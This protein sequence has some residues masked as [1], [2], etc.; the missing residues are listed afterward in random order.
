MPRSIYRVSNDLRWWGSD[1]IPRSIYPARNDFSTA[2]KHR[3]KKEMA[4]QC[5]LFF[6]YN[7]VFPAVETGVR[8]RVYTQGFNSLFLPVYFLHLQRSHLLRKSEESDESFRVVVIIEIAGCKGCE[9]LIVEAVRG[10]C[11]GLNDVAFVE[12]EFD[13]A[14]HVLLSGLDEGLLRLAK[15]R[16]PFSFIDKAGKLVADLVLD[17]VSLA[18]EDKFF[19]LL[20]RFHEDRSAG[21][22]IDAAGL[23]ADYAVLYDVDDA[24]AVLAAELVESAD[25]IG[26]FH[27]LAVNALGNALFE[28]H[29]HIGDLVGSCHGSLA[30]DQKVI[31]VGHQGRILEFETFVADV[32]EVA[33]TAVT[34]VSGEGEVDPVLFA[35]LDLRFTGVHCPLV[36]APCGDDAKIRSQSLDAEL[37]ADLVVALSGR[38]VAD[39]CSAFLAGDLYKFLG[40]QRTG[41]GGAQKVFVLIDSVGLDAGNDILLGELVID[42]Q[43]I[44]LGSAAVFCTLFE[45]IELFTLAAV[46]ADTDDVKIVVLF[47]PRDDGCGI[48]A[49]AIGEDYFFFLFGHCEFLHF[50]IYIEFFVVSSSYICVLY[51][52]IIGN[53]IGIMNII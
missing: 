11:A 24:D 39:R 19:E 45:V 18:I 26:N 29:G 36:A 49:A 44:Q 46:D 6:D 2:G 40:D 22:L 42:I 9:A 48:E 3:R 31:V 41:H 30:E 34:A 4:P 35:E 50:S 47:E 38:A 28:G 25:D 37:E 7:L 13:F 17:F 15:R 5:H 1:F 12:A 14:G 23:D 51:N 33:V 21:G 32:P 16:E 10:V 53:A 27:L 8:D 43:D 20:V 52:S